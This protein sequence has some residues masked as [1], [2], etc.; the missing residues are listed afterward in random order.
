MGKLVCDEPVSQFV[1]SFLSC[2][3][4]LIF[5]QDSQQSPGGFSTGFGAFEAVSSLRPKVRCFASLCITVSP[6]IHSTL[7]IPYGCSHQ[8]SC[9][10]AVSP[11]DPAGLTLQSKIRLS[12]GNVIASTTCYQISNMIGYDL[13]ILG[14]G[15]YQ[16]WGDCY[17]SCL[18][19][20]EL[21][22]R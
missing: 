13:P 20:I 12:S 2:F 1:R 5:P 4:F 6:K 9:F 14:L 22:Y 19:A 10:M 3:D 8:K 18:T 15:V 21:G 11:V 7:S 17:H 16:N